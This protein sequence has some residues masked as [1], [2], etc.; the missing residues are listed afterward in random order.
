MSNGLR[1]MII[2][3]YMYHLSCEI[4]IIINYY[5]ITR[6]K[7]KVSLGRIIGTYVLIS[8]CILLSP[9][10]KNSFFCHL[11]VSGLKTSEIK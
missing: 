10:T 9:I 11:A 1:S 8:N 7:L 2:L 4:K 6:S 3:S 5:T